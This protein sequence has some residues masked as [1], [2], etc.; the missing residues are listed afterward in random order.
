MVANSRAHRTFVLVFLVALL[1]V[2]VPAAARTAAP[3]TDVQPP[4]YA[5]TTDQFI[6][7]VREDGM[8][9][10][11]RAD[12]EFSAAI[13]ARLSAT[14]ADLD[15]L[16]SAG[17]PN[18]LVVKLTE[19]LSID[20]AEAF[21]ARLAADPDVAYVEPD[22]RMFVTRLPTD[23]CFVNLGFVPGDQCY[24]HF[25]WH[26]RGVNKSYSPGNPVSYGVN[27]PAAWDVTTGSPSIVTAIIDTGGLLNHADL[28][29]R[30]PTGN[31]GYDLIA[32]SATANDGGGRDADPSDPGDWIAPEDGCGP[33]IASS[34]HGSHVAGTIGASANN[35]AGIAGV[36][37]N[38]KLLHIRALGKCGGYTSDIAAAVRWAAGL[39]V[40]GVPT[41][42]NPARVINMSLGGFGTCGPDEL[43]Q[44]AIT[45]VTEKGAIV[46]VAS[47]NENSNLDRSGGTNDVNPAE[48]DGVI[49]VGATRQDGSRARY[50]NYGKTVEISAPGGDGVTDTL[51]VSS[52]N[53]GVEG[54]ESDAYAAYEGTSMATP[55]VAGVISLM[56]SANP[57][58]S[59][60]DVLAILQSTA[61]P[62]PENSSCKTTT[63]GAGIVNAG[64]AVEE[65]ARRVRTL[66]FKLSEQTVSEGAG[67]VNIR[68]QLSIPSSK[69]IAVPFTVSGSAGSADLVLADG[70]LTIPVG[71]ATGTITFAVADDTLPEIDETVVVTLGAPTGSPAPASLVGSASH[72]VTILDN[73]LG[74][75][76]PVVSLGATAV[77]EKPA[78]VDISFEVQ[79][80]AP[81]NAVGVSYTVRA[82]TANGSRTLVADG[83]VALAA[84]ENSKSVTVSI[85]RAL[86]ASAVALEVEL[87]AP[88][89]GAVLGKSVEQQVDLVG[90]RK[91]F[92]PI[93]AR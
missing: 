62:F 25:M 20:E 72:T 28:A 77:A 37:W 21:A 64:A 82:L 83:D 4:A 8:L 47:G 6:V 88:T 55:H 63:C 42:P 19:E 58:L 43:L 5:L 68:V 10:V 87:S 48:C 41:N 81:E 31:P 93:T 56:L 12:G 32:D 14:D 22:R 78:G 9:G 49:T 3:Q 59:R 36:S 50:S 54:P 18:T 15:Y 26:L 65:A 30:T 90:L 66:G 34:W 86:L 80:V 2:A 40:A 75:A 1:L 33:A 60:A 51:V 76:V 85:D 11:A 92:L 7:H 27:L 24:N 70:T 84:K 17:D 57:G 16:G 73:E 29:G 79:R 46:V 69:P 91:L 71:A 61:T 52:I 38:S 39:S 45:A 74:T 44:Q 35:G 13:A 23:P 89:G 67:T 53:S